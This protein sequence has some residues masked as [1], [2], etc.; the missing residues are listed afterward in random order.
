MGIEKLKRLVALIP[1]DLHRLSKIE[2]FESKMTLQNW[3]IKLLKNE[4][5]KTNKF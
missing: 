2:A 3:I 4:L 5:K 1:A